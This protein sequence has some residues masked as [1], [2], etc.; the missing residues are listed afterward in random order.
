MTDV[1]IGVDGSK[2]SRRAVD[3]AIEIAQEFELGLIIVHV[4]PWSPYSFSTP[5]ENEHRHAQRTREIQAA[6]EQVVDP[7]LHLVA[8]SHLKAESV[9]RHGHPVELMIALA[10]ERGVRHI[11]VGRTGDSRVKQVLFGSTPSQL[12]VSS[13]VPVT[14]VP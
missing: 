5:D 6:Q 11:I 10:V 2:A 9:V 14:V 4:I 8:N 13:P 3:F 12:I 7:A 1:M